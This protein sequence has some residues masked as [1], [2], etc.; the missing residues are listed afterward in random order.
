MEVGQ[1]KIE[2]Q[3]QGR[4]NAVTTCKHRPGVLKPV[5]Q[6]AEKEAAG[7]PCCRVRTQKFERESID[8]TETVESCNASCDKA[9]RSEP[10]SV[11]EAECCR[12]HESHLGHVA[13]RERV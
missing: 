1:G 13:S 7:E 6:A 9:T 11:V 5:V 3:R 8:S 2:S 4:M 12:P 10:L